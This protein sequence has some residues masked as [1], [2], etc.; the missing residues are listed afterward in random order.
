MSSPV[1]FAGEDKV[2]PGAA[3]ELLKRAR[4]FVP[5]SNGPTDA[6]GGLLAEHLTDWLIVLASD[7]VS[8]ATA[9]SAAQVSG[10]ARLRLLARLLCDACGHEGPLP[11]RD[12]AEV[13]LRLLVSGCSGR[14]SACAQR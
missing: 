10:K 6:S 2:P 11:D 8:T 12:A 13:L 3:E 4:R 7:A 9:E 5:C 14:P 1:L